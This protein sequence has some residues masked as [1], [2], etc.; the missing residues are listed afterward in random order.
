MLEQDI[1]KASQSPWASPIVLVKKKNGKTRFCVDYR[2]INKITKRDA[3]PLPRIDEILDSLE[4]A[5]WFS[6]LNLASG[7][8][9]VEIREDDKEKT[10]F[11]TK[12]GIYEFNV[13]SFRLAN[14][15]A[16]FQRLMDR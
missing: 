2:K 7:Y 8:W 1:I 5:Q 13:I 14:A 6:S 12:F 10:T 3:Y 9:L 4:N 16:I 11:T 15:P